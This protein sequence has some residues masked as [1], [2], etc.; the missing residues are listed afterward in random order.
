MYNDIS[1]I[2]VNNEKGRKLFSYIRDELKFENTNFEWIVERNTNLIKPTEKT[3]LS[4]TFYEDIYKL[5]YKKWARKY[6]MSVDYIKKSR[7][8][9]ILKKW[10]K[11]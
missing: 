1:C 11:R 3:T 6:Y 10:I 2:S 8:I 7:V 9:T 4:D 5:G